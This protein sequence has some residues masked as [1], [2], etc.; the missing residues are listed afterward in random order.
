MAARGRWRR[1]G[2]GSLVL[3]IVCL[4]ADAAGAQKE[5]PSGD[6]PTCALIDFD[7][8]PL[9]TVLEAKLLAEVEATWLERSAI[10]EVV[11]EQELQALFT[12]EGGSERV[13]LG[14][15]LKADL[16]IMVRDAPPAAADRSAKAAPAGE[17]PVK[18][19]DLAVT[20]TRRGLRLCARA[21][22]R[23]DDAEADA[24]T[25]V[26]LLREA[27]AKYA[28]KITEIYAVPPF[29][30]RDLG[31]EYDYL[32]LTYARLL[33]QVLL[34][35]R[36]AIVVELAEARALAKEVALTDAGA[37]LTR[38]V[39]FYLLGDYR[40]ESQSGERR[41][42]LALKLMRGEKQLD[43]RL[44]RG[45]LPHDAAATLRKFAAEMVAK[46]AGA[47]P[48]AVD[49]AAEV[50]ALNR[51]EKLFSRL[52]WIPIFEFRL[53]HTPHNGWCRLGVI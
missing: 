42:S 33:E 9:A 18:A 21:V 53:N 45:A 49:S 38:D 48:G 31:Y 50:D 12:P 19:I 14:K 34:E 4:S 39:P 3:A 7:R 28:Q 36:G 52:A 13:A 46:A 29:V 6:P 51:R 23:T 25:L 8:S 44:K 41:V 32:R 16:L 10:D 37:R 22:P 24:D 5:A 1:W 35:R 30:S 47:K 2:R 11:K 43:R 40:N 26:Q 15:L 17:E 27:L 20:E